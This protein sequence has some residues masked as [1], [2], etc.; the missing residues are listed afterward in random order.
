MRYSCSTLAEHL[1][2]YVSCT[3]IS[4]EWQTLSAHVDLPLNDLVCHSAA[5][6]CWPS[7]RLSTFGAG[8]IS[9]CVIANDLICEALHE[10]AR[11]CLE[12]LVQKGPTSHTVDSDG[13]S[14]SA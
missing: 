14:L 10:M 13:A 8:E 3:V 5:D 11:S 7:E 1:V 9:L 2:L 4:T 12:V 6:D